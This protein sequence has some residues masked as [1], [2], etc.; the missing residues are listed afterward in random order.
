MLSIRT[1]TMDDAEMLLAWRNSDRVRSVSHDDDIVLLDTHLQ[2]L[3]RRLETGAHSIVVVEYRGEPA[4]VVRCDAVDRQAGTWSWSCNAAD[5]VTAPGVGA[6]LPVIGLGLGFGR[7]QATRMVAEVLASNKNMN[8]IHRRLG[9]PLI[10]V[11]NGGAERSGGTV[12]DVNEFCVVPDDW[13]AIRA[14][15]SRLLPSALASSLNDALN[16]LVGQ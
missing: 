9:I 14:R 8:G 6:T 5:S 15:I 16:N 7:L 11:R 1:P 3:E 12:V 10:Q 4:G 2:W 13:A